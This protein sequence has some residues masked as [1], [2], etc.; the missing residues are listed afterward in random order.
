MDSSR[1]GDL[2]ATIGSGTSP[3][4]SPPARAAMLRSLPSILV[5]NGSTAVD[6]AIAAVAIAALPVKKTCEN[7]IKAKIKCD[8][9]LPCERCGKRGRECIYLAEQKRGRRTI[10]HCASPSSSSSSSAAAASSFP[11]KQ[12][13]SKHLKLVVADS[14]P[15]S[16]FERRMFRLT[17]SLFKFHHDDKKPAWFAKLFSQL[18]SILAVREADLSELHAFMQCNRI[19]ALSSPTSAL[20]CLVNLPHFPSKPRHDP[21]LFFLGSIANEGA[22]VKCCENAIRWFGYTENGSNFPHPSQGSGGGMEVFPWGADVLCSILEQDSQVL[23]YLRDVAFAFS[24]ASS[25]PC[26]Q[27]GALVHHVKLLDRPMTVIAAAVTPDE[28]AYKTVRCLVSCQIWQNKSTGMN[29]A[30]LDFYLDPAT[31]VVTS[32]QSPLVPL[33]DLELAPWSLTE[34]AL[35]LSNLI[36]WASPPPF[37]PPPPQSLMTKQTQ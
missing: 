4:I 13:D 14:S 22:R 24:T 9:K 3:V 29:C 35:P 19:S 27:F 34:G 31:A 2:S 23:A 5:P 36:Q 6:E 21:S 16:T 1:G 28:N 30:Q 10:H 15:V 32:S 8:G 25:Q 12:L 7:C 26:F 33:P 18:L 11:S 37:R 20:P 17:F